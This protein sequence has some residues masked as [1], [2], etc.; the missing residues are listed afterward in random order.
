MPFIMRDLRTPSLSPWKP[1]L[2][3]PRVDDL[4]REVGEIF[5][6]TGYQIDILPSLKEGDCY[7]VQLK[8]S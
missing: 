6:V 3:Y 2:I 7:G 1:L 8:A 4:K 5:D